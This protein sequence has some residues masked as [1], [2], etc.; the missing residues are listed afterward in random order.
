MAITKNL[1][2]SDV[3]HLSNAI[4]YCIKDKAVLQDHLQNSMEYVGK[5]DKATSTEKSFLNIPLT[6]HSAP[7]RWYEEMARAA[8][9]GRDWKAAARSK[10]GKEPVAWHYVQ[11]FGVEVAPV[12][13]KEIGEKLMAEAFS[14]FPVLMGTHSDTNYTHNH[15]IVCA[16]G[17]DGK[18]WNQDNR[19]YNKIR[20]ISDRL[21]EEY[22]LP[23]L[24]ETKTMKLK[25]HIDAAGNA[26]KFEVT[27]RKKELI[28]MR[29][30]GELSPDDVSS[31]RNTPTYRQ[32]A[33]MEQTKSSVISA[34]IDKLLPT[35]KSYDELLEKLRGIGYTIKDRKKNGELL[36][37][38]SYLPP[39][40]ERAIRETKLG[41]GQFY[42]RENLAGVIEGMNQG[43]ADIAAPPP[44]P[45]LA[46]FADY[47]IGVDADT[48]DEN[49]RLAENPDGSFFAKPR[50]EAERQTVTYAKSLYME[51]KDGYDLSALDKIIA[52]Q[53]KPLAA[54]NTG[55]GKNRTA[56]VIEQIRES[57]HNLKFIED[58]NIVSLAMAKERLD[59]LVAQSKA[60]DAS[61]EA[62]DRII[63][64]Y[65]RF[66]ATPKELEKLKEAK[67]KHAELTN[68]LHGLDS[69][70]VNYE[71]CV[72]VLERITGK[73][74][75]HIISR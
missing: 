26:R 5:E 60:A 15:F 21:C 17:M 73:G 61:L 54:Q 51:L 27:E 11:N 70:I 43:S 28:Q 2:I 33:E 71:T 64:Q 7:H 49:F 19:V 58:K 52:G 69:E 12:V 18:K 35:A 72:R 67:A 45:K 48:V 16:F 29:E 46:Y 14:N 30:A 42:L 37:Y 47:E 44:P 22:G 13:A 68:S 50:P 9:T 36:K 34:D 24:E 32:T 55:A 66:A 63:S 38:V 39:S 57:W 65:E 1:R 40:G 31:Y 25:T 59:A 20:S 3:G 41:D 74:K 62:A 53:K 8:R 23:T 4:D 75:N 56:D 10:D 6:Y